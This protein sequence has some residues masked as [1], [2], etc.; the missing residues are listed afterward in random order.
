MIRILNMNEKQVKKL[1]SNNLLIFS[2]LAMIF[3]L[4]APAAREYRRNFCLPPAH[5]LYAWQ[6]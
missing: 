5:L 1:F 4:K 2:I 6:S 3:V